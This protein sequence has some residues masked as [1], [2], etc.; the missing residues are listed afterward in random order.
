[1]DFRTPAFDRRGGG[2]CIGVPEDQYLRK[3]H[4]RWLVRRARAGGLPKTVVNKTKWGGQAADWDPRVRRDR[5]LI[6]AKMKGPAVNLEVSSILDIQRL[7]AILDS[8]PDRQPAE[9]SQM[10]AQ[11]LAVPTALGVACF[12]QDMTGAN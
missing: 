8:W 1:L 6:S 4:D 3:R 5:K 7:T 10:E 12:I 2:V 11:L 9:Y